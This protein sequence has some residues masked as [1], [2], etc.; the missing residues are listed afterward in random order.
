VPLLLKDNKSEFDTISCSKVIAQL[1]DKFAK[2]A[3][4]VRESH[5]AAFE[6][7]LRTLGLRTFDLYRDNRPR[8]QQDIIL[9]QFSLSKTGVRGS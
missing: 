7:E 9:G 8:R 5:A 2:S 4:F 3:I 1:K 6:Q